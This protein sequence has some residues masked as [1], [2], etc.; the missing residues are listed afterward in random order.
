MN[1]NDTD[2]R[3]FIAAI[4]DGNGGNLDPEVILA[5]EDSA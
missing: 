4:P 2:Q 5:P 3:A 1:I